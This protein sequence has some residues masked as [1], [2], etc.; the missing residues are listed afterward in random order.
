MLIAVSSGGIFITTLVRHFFGTLLSGKVYKIVV[1]W[2]SFLVIWEGSIYLGIFRSMLLAAP[3]EIVSKLLYLWGKGY[4]QMNIVSTLGRFIAGFIIATALAV[5]LGIALGLS[6][7]IYDWTASFLNFIRMIP[8]TAILP[9]TILLLGIGEG[10]AIFVIALGSFFPILLNTVQGVREAEKIHIE[11]I[12]TMG[13]GRAD[14]LKHVIIPSALP[15]ILTGIRIGFGIGW[16][17]LVSA[18]IV[19]SDSGL[20]FM[21]EGAR[22]RLETPTVFAGMTTI[23]ALGLVMD[24]F[25]KKVEQFFMIRR[26]RG[27]AFSGQPAKQNNKSILTRKVKISC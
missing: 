9:F 19:A 15:T 26:S 6:R 10:P 17:V 8:P 4:L 14:V 23:C 20:G 21:I 16:L 12:Q 7:K 13:G 24:F 25:L 1:A 3:S 22:N 11:V 5:P 27:P 2:L 18:E